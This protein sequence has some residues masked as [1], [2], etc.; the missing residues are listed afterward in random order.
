MPL[1]RSISTEFDTYLRSLWESAISVF[2]S[3]YTQAKNALVFRPWRSGGLGLNR[4]HEYGRLQQLE[5]SRATR[6][7]FV[8]GTLGSVGKLPHAI[9]LR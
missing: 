6:K 1:P 4:N 9:N 3:F 8:D 5:V 2:R 7:L